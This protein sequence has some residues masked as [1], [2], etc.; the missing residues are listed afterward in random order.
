[1]APL[2]APRLFYLAL[3]PYARS[4]LGKLAFGLRAWFSSARFW[5]TDADPERCLEGIAKGE[6]CR[7]EVSCGRTGRSPASPA[8][9]DGGCCR[10]VAP[11]SC[12]PA[13]AARSA[14]S[15]GG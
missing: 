13:R 10:V 11:D 9:G 1:M 14:R 7:R 4:P 15:G 12:R 6:G 2:E 5:V 3:K 8:S